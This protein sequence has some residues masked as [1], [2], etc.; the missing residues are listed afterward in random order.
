M[1]SM[2]LEDETIEHLFFQCEAAQ[3]LWRA[4]N[5]GLDFSVGFS[6][7]FLTGWSSGGKMYLMCL[8]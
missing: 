4:S 2:G 8:S 6:Y 5:L 7:L 3:R 1:S